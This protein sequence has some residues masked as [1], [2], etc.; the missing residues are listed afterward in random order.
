MNR[1]HHTERLRQMLE[2]ALRAAEADVRQRIHSEHDDASLA[3]IEQR[4]RTIAGIKEALKRLD[5]GGY[6]LCGECG[7]AIAGTRLRALPFALLCRDCQEQYELTQ[8]V[9]PAMRSQYE[10]PLT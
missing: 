1:A 2:E 9:R 4:T 6:G 10:E 5:D 7:T 8:L 3:V